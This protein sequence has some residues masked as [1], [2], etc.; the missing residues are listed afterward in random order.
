MA[1]EFA[2][3]GLSV[4]IVDKNTQRTD[5]SKAL[6]LWARTLELIDRMS[7]NGADRF[8]RAGLKTE[9]VKILSGNQTIGHADMKEVDSQYKFVLMIPQS[10]TE[11][12]LEEHLATLNVKAERQTELTDPG[13]SINETACRRVVIPCVGFWQWRASAAVLALLGPAKLADAIRAFVYA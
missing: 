13:V 10:E 7:P 12:L 4:R 1:S 9:S 6:V 5:K 8:I 11:R 3:Y 2:R